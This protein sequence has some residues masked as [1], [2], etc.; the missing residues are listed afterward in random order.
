MI[1]AETYF[2][3]LSSP[4]HMLAELT[5]EIVTGVILYP[6]GRRL[7]RRHDRNIHNRR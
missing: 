1:F 7:L 6:L 3:V 4:A 2:E 5:V